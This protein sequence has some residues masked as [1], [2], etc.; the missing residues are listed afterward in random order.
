MERL[1]GE[2]AGSSRE[3][4]AWAAGLGLVASFEDFQCTGAVAA[5][6][7]SSAAAALGEGPGRLVLPPVRNV[8]DFETIS[9][10]SG[11]IE[12]K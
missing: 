10:V 5:E 2:R 7:K 8:L 6:L 11:R 9:N 12:V 1:K 3:A 4:A